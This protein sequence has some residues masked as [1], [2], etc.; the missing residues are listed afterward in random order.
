[1]S[2]YISFLYKVKYSQI[3]FEDMRL[4][5]HRPGET[6]QN[7]PVQGYRKKRIYRLICPFF[8]LCLS[9]FVSV[10]LYLSGYFL[11]YN[12]YSRKE[13]KLFKLFKNIHR[14]LGRRVLILLIEFWF[15]ITFL[16]CI[17][18]P[19]FSGIFDIFF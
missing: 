10:W 13:S 4:M 15:S 8:C 16:P 6:V 17:S 3:M 14:L 19:A 11:S 12:F 7:L 9:V 18:M 1:M 2:S 5:N